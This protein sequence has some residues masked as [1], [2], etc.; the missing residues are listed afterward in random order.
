MM[1]KKFW[2]RITYKW[3]KQGSDESFD[4]V[5][6]CLDVLDRYPP[7]TMET[8]SVARAI[9]NNLRRVIRE[10]KGEL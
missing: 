7:D 6:N 8:D 10:T 4:A 5:L 9:I 3:W 1:L 2:G